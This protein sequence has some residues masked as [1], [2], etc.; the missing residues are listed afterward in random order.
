MH[1]SRDR[2]GRTKS[3][4]EIKG[5][6]L[7]M[8]KKGHNIYM[9]HIV[10]DLKKFYGIGLDLSIKFHLWNTSILSGKFAREEKKVYCSNFFFGLHFKNMF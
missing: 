8:T 6:Q 5:V 9:R 4:L 3:N 7:I 10:I 2:P 1:C